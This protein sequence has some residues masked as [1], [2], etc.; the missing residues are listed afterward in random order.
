MDKS[1]CDN[2]PR[3]R[4]REESWINGDQLLC[5][6]SEIVP[7]VFCFEYLVAHGWCGFVEAIELIWWELFFKSRPLSDISSPGS[8]HTFRLLVCWEVNSLYHSSHN[9]E[10]TYFRLIWMDKDDGQKHSE[11]MRQ[12]QSSLLQ[13]VSVKNLAHSD[14]KITNMPDIFVE[15]ANF[16]SE[17]IYSSLISFNSRTC[18]YVLWCVAIALSQRW[19]YFWLEDSNRNDVI[20]CWVMILQRKFMF[21]TKILLPWF[22]PWWAQGSVS[23]SNCLWKILAI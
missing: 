1:V 16:L 6:E 18:Q 22:I 15:N 23:H 7:A 14:T 8:C 2:E 3:C 12:N 20:T 4:A 13:V 19:A 17:P 9:H 10:L 5:C 11:A 21:L